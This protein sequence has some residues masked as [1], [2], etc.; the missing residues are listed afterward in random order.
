M[1]KPKMTESQFRQMLK[2]TELMKLWIM[3]DEIPEA[4]EHAVKKAKENGYIKRTALEEFNELA[5]QFKT[6][7]SEEPIA[8]IISC[9]RAAIKEIQQEKKQ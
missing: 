3:D 8:S 6:V 2:D 9:A 4:E 1:E 7:P 5:E